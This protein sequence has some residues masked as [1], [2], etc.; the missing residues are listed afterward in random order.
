MSINDII[1][2]LALGMMRDQVENII[3]GWTR[4]TSQLGVTAKLELTYIIL[5]SG[6]G[7]WFG[8]W[9]GSQALSGGDYDTRIYSG[10]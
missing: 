1:V 4:D 2:D 10:S 7:L 6:F 5:G 8:F 9:W 3:H